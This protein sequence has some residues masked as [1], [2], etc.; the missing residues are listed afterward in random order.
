MNKVPIVWQ[1][2]APQTRL[3]CHLHSERC[4]TNIIKEIICSETIPTT[5]TA[6]DCG[7]VLKRKHEYY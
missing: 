1:N 5:A 7:R 3:S 4:S 2:G 6:R